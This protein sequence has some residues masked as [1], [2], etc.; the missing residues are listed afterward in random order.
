MQ[1]SEVLTL[2]ALRDDLQLQ[3]GPTAADGSPSWTIHDPLRGRYFRVG[4]AAFQMLSCWSAGSADKLIEQVQNQSTCR[5]T[6][7]DVR[8]F[9]RFLYANQLTRQ[10]VSSDYQAYLQQYRASRPPWYRQ[11][12]HG[13][14]FFRIPLLRPDR[15]LRQTL[16]YLQ[17]CFDT[18]LLY[19]LI[20]VALLALYLASRQ[21]DSFCAT[22]LHFFDWQGALFYGL[23][24]V[25]S[26]AFHELGHAYTAV[27]YGCRVPT[28]GIAFMALFPMPYTDVSDAW[29][30]PLNRQRLAIGAAGI[31]VELA[32]AILATLAWSFLPDGALR[33][34]AFILATTTWLMTLSVNLSPF[35]RFDGYYM[36]ADALGIDNLQ[37]RAFAMA[38]WQ[39]RRW[40][41]GMDSAK[42]E[43]LPAGL[44]TKMLA[45]AYLTWIYRLLVY[46]GLAL[47]VYEFFFKL[48]GLILFAVEIIWFIWRPIVNEL[49]EWQQLGWARVSRRRKQAMLAGA[50][51]LSVLVFTPWSDSV[52]IPAILEAE[53]HTELYAPEAARIE[54]ILVEAGQRVAADQIL[55]KLQAP[56]LEDDIR[57]SEKRLDYYRLRL[58]RAATTREA[59][60]D[61]RVAMRQWSAEM[62]KLAGLKQQRERLLIRA[63]FAG[64]VVDLADSLHPKRW[65]DSAL[66]LVTVV[67]PG[68]ATIRGI[69]DE[70]AVSA[71][72]LGRAGRFV[73][74]DL[75]ATAVDARV[76]EI[77]GVNLRELD[78]PYLASIHDGTVAVRENSEGDLA[79]SA[80]VF[81]V[82]LTPNSPSPSALAKVERGTV[83]IEA[84]PRS[85]AGRLFDHAASLLLRESGF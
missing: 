8:E 35:M 12:V 24:L 9:V 46:T 3:A 19:A 49:R 34:A 64:D 30:L 84:T 29:R 18:R 59:S 65:I 42:P 21:W 22:F 44:Q 23:A 62:A 39:L 25:F 78:S 58:E 6:D 54:G 27:R 75:T 52:R 7:A 70:E 11:L 68:R 71:L 63:P 10:A 56:K 57:L 15:F 50:I 73:P 36:L 60:A 51:L 72:A 85:Y 28:I 4:W 83:I 53:Q 55:L 61:M 45:Y 20:A 33:S 13:Y 80:S 16:P 40:L 17:W 31:I 26:K 48:L 82:R 14:L 43:A 47:M 76:T 79:P 5:L 66:P 81:S 32:L 38:R 67:A 2:P 41:L 37:P 1:D 77:G 74:E 69:A